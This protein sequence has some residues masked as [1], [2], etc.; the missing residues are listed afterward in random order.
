M[1]IYSQD[2]RYKKKAEL[3]LE[4]K[5]QQLEGLESLAFPKKESVVEKDSQEKMKKKIC[6]Y[7]KDRVLYG[8]TAGPSGLWFQTEPGN[9]REV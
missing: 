1:I 4:V 7:V 3:P 9:M 6:E 5:S 8:D 2:G